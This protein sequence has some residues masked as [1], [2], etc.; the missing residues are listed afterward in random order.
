MLESG[1]TFKL[2]DCKTC[3]SEKSSLAKTWLSVAISS[4]V[5]KALPTLCVYPDPFACARKP[6][7][8]EKAKRERKKRKRAQRGG[9]GKGNKEKKKEQ[10][11]LKVEM[12]VM[13]QVL[14]SLS[15]VSVPALGTLRSA[16]PP[17]AIVAAV[18]LFIYF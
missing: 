1:F 3:I 14:T 11:Q 7:N 12:K 17:V 2:T 10:T 6:R 15:L 8:S 13:G 5:R 9:G 16:F 4:S 18:Y